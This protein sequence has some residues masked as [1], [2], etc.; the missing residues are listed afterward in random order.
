MLLELIHETVFEYAEPVC[1]SY[2][3]FR[4]TP[5]SDVKQHVLQHRQ[6]V[7]PART[8]RQY[9]DAYGNVVNYFNLLDMHTRVEVRFDSVVETHEDCFR[10]EALPAS[11]LETAPGRVTLHD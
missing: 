5:L 6:R 10:G 3:E 8:I 7:L 4:L 11:Q 2:L 1:E 9:T